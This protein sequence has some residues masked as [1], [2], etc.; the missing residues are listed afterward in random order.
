MRLLTAVI[1]AADGVRFVASEA[2]SEALARRLANYVSE[3]CDDSLWPPTA[4][5]VRRLIANDDLEAAIAAYFA[6]VGERWD[7]EWLELE[8]ATLAIPR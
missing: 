1:H 5:R 6:N 2:S 7:D 3:R 4:A 8:P